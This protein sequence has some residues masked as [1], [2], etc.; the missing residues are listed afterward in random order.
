VTFGLTAVLRGDANSQVD[1]SSG[2]YA[3]GQVAGVAAATALTEGIASG[4]ETA[5]TTS[6]SLVRATTGH[7]AAHGISPAMAQ[8]A[9]Q[10]GEQYLDMMHP[11]VTAH[12]IQGGMASGRDLYVASSAGKVVTAFATKF[13]PATLFQ[14]MASWIPLP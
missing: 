11:D 6:T 4:A 8:K 10:V 2:L 12:V 9:I 14:G 13:N 7:A 5:T 3:A 1:R